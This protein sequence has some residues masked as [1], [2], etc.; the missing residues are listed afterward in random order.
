M[1]KRYP[2]H[3]YSK[4]ISKELTTCEFFLRILYSPM[5][6]RGKVSSSV[7]KSPD[8]QSGKFN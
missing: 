8:P 4:E 3:V 1:L 5:Q 7:S 6:S 2:T